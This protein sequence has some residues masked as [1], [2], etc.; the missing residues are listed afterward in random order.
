MGNGDIQ[1]EP[2]AAAVTLRPVTS[3]DEEFLV[4]VYA[5]TRAEELAQVQWSADQQ[6]QFVRWQYGLQ[7]N[8][9]MAR[10]PD[11][12]YEV[13]LVDGHPAGR[14]WVGIDDEQIRLLDIALLPEFQ[15]RG[16]GTLL[17]H[18]LIEEA[19]RA[20]KPLRHMVFVLNNDAH[21]FYERLGFVVI[22]DLGA[23]QH[24][25]YHPKINPQI[26]PQITQ[27]TQIKEKG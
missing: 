14:I 10:F 20:G 15:N 17:I 4:E 22:E 19:S 9:Y 26:N 5:S 27:I 2:T 1:L 18:Q 13:I 8:E 25:E 12:R 24:M 16:V 21:R 7:Q 6:V 3:A 11:A 23:Y